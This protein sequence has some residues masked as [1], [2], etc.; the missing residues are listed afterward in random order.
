M[1][2]GSTGTANCG[3]MRQLGVVKGRVDAQQSVDLHAVRA[4]AGWLT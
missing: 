4:T 2:G 1:Q 3:D